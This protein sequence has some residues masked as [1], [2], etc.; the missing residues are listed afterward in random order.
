MANAK[1]YVGKDG[2]QQLYRRIKELLGRITGYRKVPGTGNDNHPDVATPDTRII[3]L[4]KIPEIVGEDKYKEWIWEV[5]SQGEGNWECI[6]STSTVENAW[7]AWS[8]DNGSTS[9]NDNAGK[10]IYVGPDNTISTY[11][12]VAIGRNNTLTS[13]YGS[14]VF[15][16]E[17]TVTGAVHHSFAIGYA[18]SVKGSYQVN[19]FGDFNKID[20]T[21][22]G[23]YNSTILGFSNTI[24][25]SKESV[26]M[27]NGSA[28]N[29][30]Y[31][32]TII[33]ANNPSANTVQW[34][35]VVGNHSDVR[36]ARY[37]TAVGSAIHIAKVG[38]DPTTG[39]P[40]YLSS[41]NTTAVGNNMTVSGQNN[42]VFG[43][44]HNV[45]G[46]Q[47]T[48]LGKGTVVYGN[49][50]VSVGE[51]SQV[52]GN[53]NILISDYTCSINGRD[54]SILIGRTSSITKDSS[55][56]TDYSNTNLIAVG[57]YNSFTQAANAYQI[58]KNNTVTENNLSSLSNY[59]HQT[60][61]NIGVYNAITKEGVNIG[62]DNVAT[63]YG[64]NIGRD[65]ESN[66]D[67]LSLGRYA[68][69]NGGSIALGKG[70][71]HTDNGTRVIDWVYADGG[72]VAIGIGKLKASNSGFVVGYDT[73][74]ISGHSI[75][76]GLFS[77][78]QSQPTTISGSSGGFI[79]DGLGTLSGLNTYGVSRLD[80]GSMGIGAGLTLGS[81]ACAFGMTNTGTGGAFIVGK[82]NTASE[83]SFI[84]GR[85]NSASGGANVIGATNSYINSGSQ[86]FGDK[87]KY[88][89]LGS[90]VCGIENNY[91]GREW[92]MGNSYIQ[93]NGGNKVIGSYNS[94]IT[95]GISL[96]GNSCQYIYDGASTVG[97]YNNNIHNGAWVFGD[98]ISYAYNGAVAIGTGNQY[99]Y[100]SGWAIG[101]VLNNIHDD[102]IAYGDTI[103]GVSNGSVAIGFDLSNVW[104]NSIDIG[105][106]NHTIADASIALGSGNNAVRYGSIALGIGNSGYR[107]AIMLGMRNS[108]YISIY[109]ETF[110]ANSVILGYDNIISNIREKFKCTYDSSYN[111]TYELACGFVSGSANHAYGHNPI[112]I[113][114]NNTVGDISSWYNDVVQVSDPTE[115]THND[116]FMTAI[117]YKCTSLRNYDM[118][119]GYMSR[120]YGG[121][122]VALQHSNA[123]GYRNLAA[124]DSNINGIANVGLVESALITPNNS[125]YSNRTQNMLFASTV[126]CDDTTVFTKNIALYSGISGAIATLGVR[127]NIFHTAELTGRAYVTFNNIMFGNSTLTSTITSPTPAQ[128]IFN[129]IL[130]AGSRCTYTPDKSVLSGSANSPFAANI[131]FGTDAKNAY[132]CFSMADGYNEAADLQHC[133]RVF[134]FGDNILKSVSTSNVL[135]QK[136][137]VTGVHHSSILGES[138]TIKSYEQINTDDPQ[139]NIYVGEVYMMGT[140]NTV[141]HT[142]SYY[143]SM[144]SP[145]IQI[146]R[147]HIFGDYNTIY[148]KNTH[149]IFIGGEH[150]TIGI[151][152][153][154]I[155]RIAYSDLVNRSVGSDT[156]FYLTEYTYIPYDD[157]TT[158]EVCYYSDWEAHRTYY[159]SNGALIDDSAPS[160][161][162]YQQISGNDLVS[163]T[164]NKTLVNNTW[165]K[166]T[167]APSKEQGEWP[168]VP[169]LAETMTV[170]KHSDGTIS[171]SNNNGL[172]ETYRMNRG[173]GIFGSRNEIGDQI[174][175]TY[176]FGQENTVTNSLEYATSGSFIQGNNNTVQ[177]G[178][179][180]ISMGNG[181]TSIGHNSVAI[182]SQLI[183]NQ[184]QT[185]IGKYNVAKPGPSRTIANFSEAKT[186][187]TGDVVYNALGSTYYKCTAPISTVGLWVPSEWTEVEPENDKALFIIGNGY[188]ETDGEDWQDESKIHRSNAM[189]VYAD[190]TVK[191]KRFVADEPEI[192]LI[193]GAGIQITKSVSSGTATISVKQPLPAAP[194]RRGTYALQCV[195]TEDN[196]DPTFSWVE[197]GT[198][199]V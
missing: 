81:S 163:G 100:N 73:A 85:A 119:I 193:E 134:N 152:E 128:C 178:S 108:A 159:Y 137:N 154:P 104:T 198:T 114:V 90:I 96:L 186:Y 60:A 155:V 169:A 165:Y 99:I 180:I 175:N 130:L 59:P 173:V 92:L 4:V 168:R 115:E 65:S 79:L 22:L 120:A 67:S 192:E 20:N 71:Y 68:Y 48:I 139:K 125:S 93:A 156:V 1:I 26:I 185:V 44:L 172:G 162:T 150:N 11:N 69:S 38:T 161:T 166:I 78:V 66:N 107:G 51:G 27:A 17:N 84:F 28:S 174:A 122:N 142:G 6:G 70:S 102:G 132:N 91:I 63:N 14:H 146:S 89:D 116:G 112:V 176:V 16:L 5:P 21:N 183:S 181:H 31:L 188:S 149:D 141:I 9:S 43:Y 189:E 19:V 124:F 105:S 50:N 75:G 109:S 117:G 138:N 196:G 12:A 94:Y 177:N 37:A 40:I 184:W 103:E 33:G 2:A 46:Y 45:D 8:E 126:T 147:L 3:Y 52:K 76:V 18:N 23:T 131:L 195:I 47:N 32:S 136:N 167:S 58:G 57:E 197:I 15:G 98:S 158:T 111:L 53:S 127:H 140:D 179:N 35:T 39:E 123:E 42:N 24:D 95:G 87:N 151:D 97:C 55:D 160:G 34:A 36:Q 187:T 101:T 62:K 121:E 143:A 199:T 64:I 74:E 7:K 13:C 182:G 145:P 129:N 88:V 133:G 171:P 77:V 83:G 194:S 135:G 56:Q 49:D 29:D 30:V 61:V 157:G 164:R 113:G 82:Y 10:S 148:G 191:A 110:H 54:D 86:V 41:D 80:G 25:K 170:I 144:S 118:A 190:G 153:Q 72:S 106:Q